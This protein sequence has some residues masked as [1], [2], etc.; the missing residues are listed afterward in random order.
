MPNHAHQRWMGKLDHQRQPLGGGDA[1]GAPLLPRDLQLR[2][3][4]TPMTH[5]LL[6]FLCA[7]GGRV[8]KGRPTG[9]HAFPVPT[10]PSLRL[11][12][13]AASGQGQGQGK[14]RQS[15]LHC[16]PY[17]VRF[18]PPSAASRSCPSPGPFDCIHHLLPFFFLSLS[19]SLLRFGFALTL[20]LELSSIP[21]RAAGHLP[22]TARHDPVDRP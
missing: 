14:A 12:V 3:C 6:V 10:S 17:G 15:P 13:P 19:L 9:G 2:T 5:G 7:S 1:A 20:S 16:N 4:S 8:V 11:A 22:S 18:V 21:N